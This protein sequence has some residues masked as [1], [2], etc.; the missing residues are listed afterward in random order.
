MKIQSVEREKVFPNDMINKWLT[1]N[2][3]KQTTQ[4]QANN[5]PGYLKMGRKTEEIF[6]Q[7]A[8]ADGQQA[9]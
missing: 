9:H 8:Y 1:L 2:I 6:F 7:Q 3:H 4:Q 5:Q